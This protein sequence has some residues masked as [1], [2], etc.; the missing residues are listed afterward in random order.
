MK[1]LEKKLKERKAGI[2]VIG[3][4]YVGLPLAVEQSKAGFTV[5][6]IER[7]KKRVDMVNQG[8][9]YIPDVV[10]SELEKMVKEG[11]LR[12]TEHF[13]IISEVDVICIC[14]P[15]PLTKNKE[16][17]VQ[18]IQGV[19]NRL[20]PHLRRGQLIVLE[21]TTYPGTTKEVILPRLE[22]SGFRVGQDFY[23]AYS[24]ERISPGNKKY[25]IGNTPKVVG[26]VTE[27]CSYLAKTLYEQVI[28]HQIYVVSSPGVAEMEKLLENVFRSVN[29]ALVNEMALLCRRMGISIWEVI[30][31]AKTKPYGFMCFYPGPG[32][33]GHCIPIDPFYLA[34]KAK[35]YDFNTRFIELAGEINDR[36]PFYV[37]ERL[38]EILNQHR[39]CLNGA[40]IL[41]L[42]V[43]YKK[44]IADL[45]ESPALKII[46]LLEKR[47]AKVSYH[48]PHIATFSLEDRRYTSIKLNQNF[49]KE[50]DIVLVTTDHSFYDYEKIVEK[51]KLIF[52]TRNA[53]RKVKNN[54]EKIYLL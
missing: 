49:L 12:A 11:K 31:A 42:G 34:W 26:G 19:T 50:A 28:D 39:I 3:L 14:V 9:N 45:R 52:D 2:A 21:S 4:G 5:I 27:K 46:K 23:L 41:I 10:D 15:T 25:R 54:R 30:E 48:D 20:I 32:L 8:K 47:E 40:R 6:G 18:Y 44:D 35:E 38:T 53:T 24:P 17:N 22:K 13:E 36:M 7:K 1:S 37:V 43:T 16:P 51:S 33:G 29:I